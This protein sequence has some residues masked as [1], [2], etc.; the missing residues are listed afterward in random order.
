MARF[1]VARIAH[2]TYEKVP[3]EAQG[4][5][6]AHVAPG[7][8]ALAHGPQIGT[9]GLNP[10]GEG[11]CG[12]GFQRVAEN[13]EAAGGDHIGGEC[14]GNVRIDERFREEGIQIPFRQ[15]DVWM[16]GRGAA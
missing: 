5:A 7:V 16:R 13:I 3:A 15:V 10:L 6:A 12:V 8:C 9:I 2:G 1:G 4:L 14:T 11:S